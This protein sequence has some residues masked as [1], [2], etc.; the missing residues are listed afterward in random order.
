M[1][2]CCARSLVSCA[3]RT[4]PPTTASFGGV[5]S[6]RAAVPPQQG[7]AAGLSNSAMAAKPVKG[8]HSSQR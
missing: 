2:S 5:K 8:P 6:A 7:Q 1:G 3:R 4:E